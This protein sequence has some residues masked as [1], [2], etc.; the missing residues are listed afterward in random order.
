MTG[1][2]TVRQ[3]NVDEF[4][5]IVDLLEE[6]IRWLRD[7]GSDQWSTWQTWRA[8][9]QPT[10]ERGDVWVLLDDAEVVGTVTVERAGD[11]DFWTPDELA[12][13][14]GYVSKLTI[15]RDHAGRELGSLLLAWASDHVY[16]Q[17]GY[18][19]RLDAWKTNEQLHA[20]YRVRGWTYL[21]TSTNPRRRSGALFQTRA[22][23]LSH[24]SAQ[25][26]REVPAVSTLETHRLVAFEPDPAGNW[27]PGHTH[28]GGLTVDYRWVGER[29][30][31]FVDFLRY[32]V[33]Q[34]NGDWVLEANQADQSWEHHG[35]VLAADWPLT[36]G[37]TYVI[38]HETG[39]PCRMSIV[40]VP[41]P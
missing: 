37:T 21:R 29:P 18:W 4:G 35:L 1:S 24:S 38:T 15:R 36:P 2:M 10:L 14:A 23:P 39:D 16:R 12:E 33:R 31:M 22:R 32:R 40:D 6:S 25:L 19:L 30:A 34:V 20:Y 7:R 5:Q 28:N 41:A 11:Q 9:M 8:K 17:G 13:P 26:L 27:Q 3:S